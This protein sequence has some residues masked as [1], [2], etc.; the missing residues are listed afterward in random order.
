[1]VKVT[2]D[3]SKL[4]TAY[5]NLEREMGEAPSPW[6]VERARAGRSGAA[7]GGRATTATSFFKSHKV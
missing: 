5:F 6:L 1:M 3:R 7:P 2:E 4:P